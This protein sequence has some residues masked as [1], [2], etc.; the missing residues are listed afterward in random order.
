MPFREHSILRLISELQAGELRKQSGTN[1]LN[2]KKKKNR[3]ELNRSARC[4]HQ[5]NILY[6]YPMGAFPVKIINTDQNEQKCC[7]NIF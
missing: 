5:A 3:T 7:D 4:Q 2:G 1:K 6:K